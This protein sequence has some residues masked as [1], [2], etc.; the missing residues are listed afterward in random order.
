MLKGVIASSFC[1]LTVTK[2]YYISK[3]LQQKRFFFQQAKQQTMQYSRL[4]YFVWSIPNNLHLQDVTLSTFQEGGTDSIIKS[5]K[6]IFSLVFV[7]VLV[8]LLSPFGILAHAEWSLLTPHCMILGFT[9][10]II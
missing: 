9:D 4:G 2:K 6:K 3:A 7:L 5:K 1:M 10:Q 8:N